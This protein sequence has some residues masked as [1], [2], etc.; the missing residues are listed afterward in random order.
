MKEHLLP[1]KMRCDVELWSEVVCVERHSNRVTVNWWTLEIAPFRT[2]YTISGCLHLQHLHTYGHIVY[3]WKALFI[4]V[5]TKYAV[6]PSNDVL[7]VQWRSNKV[8]INVSIFKNVT[9][10]YAIGKLIALLSNGLFHR[11]V[12]FFIELQLY[13][14]HSCFC[15]ANYCVSFLFAKYSFI[16]KYCMLSRFGNATW[17][18]LPMFVFCSLSSS[19]PSTLNVFVDC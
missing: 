11:T 13:C 3:V 4:P 15:K 2:L 6:E 12:F 1:V 16:T 7:Y 18:V 9:M 10:C 5:T 17:N 8:I 19:S 14:D